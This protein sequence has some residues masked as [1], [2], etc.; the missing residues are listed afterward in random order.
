MERPRYGGLSR[1]KTVKSRQA[2]LPDGMRV[3]VIISTVRISPSPSRKL[4]RPTKSR[5][6]PCVTQIFVLLGGEEGHE[7][8]I[9]VIDSIVELNLNE[10][11]QMWRKESM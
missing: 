4:T 9:H 3:A 10:G 6:Q 8:Q 2:G 7:V 5:S 11:G 1:V